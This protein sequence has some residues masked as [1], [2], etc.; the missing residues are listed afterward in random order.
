MKERDHD[1]PDELRLVAARLRTGRHGADPLELD[2]LKRRAMAQAERSVRARGGRVAGARSR[3]V[4]V[5]LV[6]GVVLSGGS[7]SVIAGQRDAAPEEE[8]AVISQYVVAEEVVAP[9]PP[10]VAPEVVEEEPEAEEAP[11]AVTAPAPAARRLPFT[12][13]D[14]LLLLALLGALSTAAGLGLRYAARGRSGSG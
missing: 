3:L 10:E 2:E 6:L 14:I 5:M 9:P 4:T 13:T 7:A 12:G 1:L 8:S 11:P